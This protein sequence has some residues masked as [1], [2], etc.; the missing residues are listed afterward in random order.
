MQFLV[1]GASGFVGG[2]ICQ[3]LA[4]DG[5]QVRGL[6][7]PSADDA[8]LRRLGVDIRRGTLADPNA[9]AKAAENCQVVI[10]AAGESNH[11]S[12]K[13]ALSWI[14]VAGT[15]NVL[16]A[17]RHA[18]CDRLVYISCA[19][20]TLSNRDRVHW[21]ED[22]YVEHG[23]IDAHSWTKQLAEEVILS[24][25]GI[26]TTAIRPAR[27]WG[28]GDR[29]W[30]PQLCR[31]SLGGGIR[32]VGNGRNLLATTYIDHLVDAVLV[33]CEVVE[34]RGRAY[35]V[36]DGD[37][38]QARE[39]FGAFSEHTGLPQ[40]RSGL[41]FS[42]AYALAKARRARRARNE[43]GALHEEPDTRVREA[44]ASFSATAFIAGRGVCAEQG[45]AKERDVTRA[46][47]EPGVR[48]DAAERV[49]VLIVHAATDDAAARRHV[50]RRGDPRVCRQR[51]KRVDFMPS[52]P[53]TSR[54]AMRSRASPSILS[55]MRPRRST[56]MSL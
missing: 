1:T 36:N 21:N 45:I 20:V 2:R 48:G 29:R 24:A 56:P 11:R 30:L 44:S 32:M 7:R 41:P 54:S 10:H 5:E 47:K 12:A 53:K 22:H 13:R 43:F 38:L 42:A 23:P 14:N 49:G 26:E 52:G 27:I 40:P 16:R 6:L 4:E 50:L 17:S 28:P 55:R 3:R 39:F 35:Y 34:A 15:E 33:A 46:R 9:I 37:L 18:G 19:D 8:Q 31:E 25:S 51:P